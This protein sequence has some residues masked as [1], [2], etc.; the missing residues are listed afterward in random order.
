MAFLNVYFSPNT[1]RLPHDM[2]CCVSTVLCKVVM[3]CPLFLTQISL[4]FSVKLFSLLTNKFFWYTT[5]HFQSN[6]KFKWNDFRTVSVHTVEIKCLNLNANTL[7][8]VRIFLTEMSILNFQ[9][10]VK[11]KCH[12]SSHYYDLLNFKTLPYFM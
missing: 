1:I 2:T 4:S 10:H 3:L 5:R 9:K 7:A 6:S 8:I 11:Y 12:I